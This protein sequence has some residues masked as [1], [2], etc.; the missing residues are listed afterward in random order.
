MRN[1]LL[2]VSAFLVVGAS[3]ALAF[4]QQSSPNC[5]PGSWFCEESSPPA[6]TTAPPPALP[7]P[8]VTP[9]PEAP[10]AFCLQPTP[11]YDRHRPGLPI[12]SASRRH[13]SAGGPSASVG[14][15]R[16]ALASRRRLSAPSASRSH[17]LAPLGASTSASRAC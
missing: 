4:A 14:L 16:P 2:A 13:L 10:P 3:S 1:R 11:G 17:T 9:P 5:P 8:S 15:C 7:P 12:R 6:A